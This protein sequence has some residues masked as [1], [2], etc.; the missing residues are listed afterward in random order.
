M[1]KHVGVMGCGREQEQLA[2]NVL[3][4][5]AFS[6]FIDSKVDVEKDIF[7]APNINIPFYHFKTFLLWYSIEDVCVDSV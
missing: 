3:V 7:E 4:S 5:K 2:R 6:I 1:L